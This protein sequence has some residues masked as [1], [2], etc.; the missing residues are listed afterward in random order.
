MIILK[1]ST[2]DNEWSNK[3]YILEY[4]ELK[5]FIYLLFFY[6]QVMEEEIKAHTSQVVSL[7]LNSSCTLVGL[8]YFLINE[9]ALILHYVKLV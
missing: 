3:L 4:S 7:A 6:V 2:I 9:I 5:H 1:Y 8:Q